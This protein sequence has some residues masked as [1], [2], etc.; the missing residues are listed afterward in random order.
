M[1]GLRDEDALESALAQPRQ[2]LAY[3]EAPDVTRLAAAYGFGLARNHPFHH[4]N[5]RIALVT[6]AVFVGLSGHELDAPEAEAVA[7]MLG[8][9]AGDVSEEQLAGWVRSHLVRA[10][11]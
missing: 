6:M 7:V 8:L 5:K 2:Q 9:A 10:N 11:P 1:L 3:G 4:E